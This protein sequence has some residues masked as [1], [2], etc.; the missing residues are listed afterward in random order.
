MAAE[1]TMTH[2]GE[3]TLIGEDAPTH[4]CLTVNRCQRC[5][6]DHK[7]LQFASLDN[8][9]DEW[10][11][12]AMCPVKQQPILLCAVG[13]D[14]KAVRQGATIVTT[15]DPLGEEELDRIQKKFFAKYQRAP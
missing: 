11:W 12:W 10:Q 9:I 13:D 4:P 6:Q 3:K 5:G 2:D 7:D 15:G 8:A 1:N 14:A